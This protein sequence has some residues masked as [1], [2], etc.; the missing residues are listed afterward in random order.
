MICMKKNM[1]Y[2]TIVI[3][4]L[5]LSGC[6]SSDEQTFFIPTP[7]LTQEPSKEQTTEPTGETEEQAGE[8]DQE[9]S[10]KPVHVGKTTTKYV[11]L[12]NYDAILNIRSAPSREGEIVGF[13]VH[14]EQ[15]EVISIE[16]GWASFVYQDE[17]RYVSAD[18]LVDKKP[19]YIA[20][21]TSTPEPTPTKKP[22][23]SDAPPEI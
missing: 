4:V 5:I 14:T 15:V 20:P 22:D 21:P 6:K 7:A 18:F 9:T 17:I 13:L 12:D 8:D 10:D 1:I 3:A 11:K 19:A 2:L 23:P 16:D